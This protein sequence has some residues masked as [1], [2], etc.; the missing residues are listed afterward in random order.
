M[1]AASFTACDSPGSHTCVGASGGTSG[2]RPADPREG[3]GLEVGFITNGQRLT[4]RACVT[5]PSGGRRGR[6]GD[7]PLAPAL[8]PHPGSSAGCS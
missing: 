1:E 3:A 5:T 4:N 6:L 2:K 7:A 8:S